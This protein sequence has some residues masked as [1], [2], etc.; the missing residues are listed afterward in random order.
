MVIP[1]DRVDA[2]D[3]KPWYVFVL[4]WQERSNMHLIDAYNGGLSKFGWFPVVFESPLRR[5][6]L[7]GFVAD[8]RLRYVPSGARME[9]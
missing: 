2:C 3:L 8:L 7:V 5:T 9:A 6:F 1:V 4:A